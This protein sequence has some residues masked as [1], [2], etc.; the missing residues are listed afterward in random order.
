[1][2][3]TRLVQGTRLTVD[4]IDSST[5]GA[6][7]AKVNGCVVFVPFA[8][9]GERVVVRIDYVKRQ[10]ANATLL[11]IVEP[12]PHRRKPVCTRFFRCGGCSMLHIDYDK[13]L[14][15]KHQALK[16]TI[17]KNTHQEYPIDD[18]VASSPEYPYRNKLTLPF[19]L[20]EGRVSLGFYRQGSHKVVSTLKCFLNGDWAEQLIG[21]VLD[22]CRAHNLS[23]YSEETGKGLLRHLVA[24]YLDGMLSVVLVV[25][26]KTIPHQED[27]MARLGARFDKFSLYLSVN[28]ARTNVVF[29][30]QLIAL[31]EGEQYATILGVRFPVHP[32]SFVQVNLPIASKIYAEIV[33][34]VNP[35]KKTIF[36][37]A[38]AGIGVL[39]C[40]MAQRGATVYNI[41]IVKEAVVNGKK[42]YRD[43]N[44]DATFVEGD[45]AIELPKILDDIDNDS[46]V[47][48][49]LDPPRKGVAQ[50]VVDSVNKCGAKARVKLIYLSCNPA[51]LSRDMS[52]LDY[53]PVSITPYDMFPTTEHLE[54]LVFFD[55]Q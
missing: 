51:T 10:Y 42:L 16:T 33:K 39:G 43:N 9:V 49:F 35:D 38:Y 7:I 55:K 53:T 45:A 25:N 14:E 6:G 27:L 40:L 29:G 46:E 19:G 34:A 1:M 28:K 21:I 18:V 13:Q 2:Q 31:K 8:I 32:M 48:I 30:D 36:I 44:L 47:Y 41:E 50:E 24:R 26:G 15:I 20:T 22:Y 23:V 12:S 17:F 54:T 11:E 3:E 5:S 37:D 52:R 4:I